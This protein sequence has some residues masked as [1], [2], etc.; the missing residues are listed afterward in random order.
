MDVMKEG[1]FWGAEDESWRR[2]GLK[3]GI[4]F[5][6]VFY[7]KIHKV[8]ASMPHSLRKVID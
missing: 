5:T 8:L 4:Y 6:T 2:R 3:T 7:L 1:N